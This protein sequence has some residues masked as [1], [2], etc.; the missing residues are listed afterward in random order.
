M[1]IFHATVKVDQFYSA[2]GI[3]SSLTIGWKGKT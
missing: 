2:E 1:S 3:H